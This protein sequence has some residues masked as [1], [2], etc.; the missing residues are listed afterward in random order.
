MKKVMDWNCCLFVLLLL[1]VISS[2]FCVNCEKDVPDYNFPDRYLFFCF[3]FVFVVV[4][5]V[6]QV[7]LPLRLVFQGGNQQH[8]DGWMISF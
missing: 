1:G 4:V 8:K 3:F 5:V 7:F 6:N 2:P